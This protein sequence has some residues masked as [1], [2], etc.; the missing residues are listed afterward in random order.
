MTITTAELMTFGGQGV[1]FAPSANLGGAG[2]EDAG[3]LGCAAVRL[4]VLV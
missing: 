1:P 4:Q 3:E 2:V